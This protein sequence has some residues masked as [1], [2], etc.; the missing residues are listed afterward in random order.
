MQPRPMI[1]VLLTTVVTAAGSAVYAEE[2]SDDFVNGYF[3]PL[4][5]VEDHP[6]CQGPGETAFQVEFDQTSVVFHPQSTFD[7]RRCYV[8]Q[9]SGN[10]RVQAEVPCSSGNDV[11]SLAEP[12]DFA[13]YSLQVSASFTACQSPFGFSVLDSSWRADASGPTGAVTSS[14]SVFSVPAEGCS[15]ARRENGPAMLLEYFQ[16]GA[17]SFGWRNSPRF[18][19]TDSKEIEP[20]IPTHFVLSFW[21]V[22]IVTND[23][24]YPLFVASALVALVPD[25]FADSACWGRQCETR[26]SQTAGRFRRFLSSC[27]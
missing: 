13:E 27:P 5:L 19:I 12:P 18:S 8:T 20:E 7:D 4:T 21:S 3:V 17:A 22:P 10:E 2:I 14:G 26:M 25:A 9:R 1:C 15:D 16:T 23:D 11:S 24:D 6:Q